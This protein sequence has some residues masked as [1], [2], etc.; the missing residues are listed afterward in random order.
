[1]SHLQ[2][3]AHSALI[4][5]QHCP[6]HTWQFGLIRKDRRPSHLF[7]KLSLLEFGSILHE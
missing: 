2:F 1:M 6:G 7:G 5:I 4:L 3:K